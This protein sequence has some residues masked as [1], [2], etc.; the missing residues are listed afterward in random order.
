MPI[1]SRTLRELLLLIHH[2]FLD[3]GLPVTP[4]FCGPRQ[5]FLPVLTAGFGIRFCHD[6]G[7]LFLLVTPPR[8]SGVPDHLVELNLDADAGKLMMFDKVHQRHG[9]NL[10]KTGDT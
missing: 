7:L 9:L 3:K 4:P 8:A 6:W 5:P 2:I 10:T 1:S